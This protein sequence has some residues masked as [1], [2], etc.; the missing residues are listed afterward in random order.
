MKKTIK[1]L[2]FVLI[3]G[4]L[5]AGAYSVF[6]WK[7]TSGD[8][9]SSINQLKA[10]EDNLIDVVFVGSS[11]VY[12]GIAPDVLWAGYGIAAF[13]MAISGM[14]YHSEY[15]YTKHLLKTQSPKVVFVDIYSLTFEDQEEEGNF[16]RNMLAM[17]F[18]KE[19]VEL[20]NEAIDK[21]KRKDYFLRWPIIHSRYKEI[22]RGDFLSV[23]FEKYGRGEKME[24][25]A[26]HVEM[27]TARKYTKSAELTDKVKDWVDRFIA[28]SEEYG[29]ELVFYVTPYE[30][31]RQAME[32]FNAVGDYVLSTGKASYVNGILDEALEFNEDEDFIDFAHLNY[33]GAVKNS[34]YLGKMI[35]DR[36][37]LE[38]HY[39]DPAYELWDMDSKYYVSE[40]AGKYYDACF[41]F[42]DYKGMGTSL[43]END[44]VTYMIAFSKDV[45]ADNPAAIV[46]QGLGLNPAGFE[47]GGLII[48]NGANVSIISE[49]EA[50]E[51]IYDL[52]RYNAIKVVTDAAGEVVSL[53]FGDKEYFDGNGGIVLWDQSRQIS[54]VP[55]EED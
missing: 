18:S 31:N 20:I 44:Y 22:E 41:I 2:A 3:L 38:D 54:I 39:G 34:N 32:L 21:E 1:I 45:P 4:V 49:T 52:D 23:G 6:S 7:D 14:D 48:G 11:H 37:S 16:Y 53:M 5:M 27:T 30:A 15:Y 29:F 19:S 10:T 35:S 24:Y 36:F 9:C 47:K 46:L 12:C 17:P 26:N 33:Y 40:I 42:D 50:T 25:E 51:K 55:K 43:L 8:Y 13:D 28:L